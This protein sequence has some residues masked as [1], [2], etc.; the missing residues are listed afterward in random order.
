MRTLE[1]LEARFGAFTAL[2]YTSLDLARNEA[3][4][5]PPMNRE[6]AWAI[7]EFGD[8]LQRARR[9]AVRWAKSEGLVPSGTDH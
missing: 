3:E 6:T 2:A 4:D 9:G 7:P 1:I 5:A 8:D